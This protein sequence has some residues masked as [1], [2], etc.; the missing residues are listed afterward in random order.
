MLHLRPT[1]RICSGVT[2]VLNQGENEVEMGPLATAGDQLG[3]TQKT[4]EK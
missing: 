1:S 2:R 3:N 4:W